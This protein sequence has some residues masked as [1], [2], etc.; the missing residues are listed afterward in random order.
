[1]CNREWSYHVIERNAS[2]GKYQSDNNRAYKQPMPD[3][4]DLALYPTKFDNA[5]KV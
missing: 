3:F 1:M 4:F 5:V 2:T